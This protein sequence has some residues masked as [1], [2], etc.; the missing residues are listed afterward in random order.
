M[1][2]STARRIAALAFPFA[3]AACASTPPPLAPTAPAAPAPIVQTP[4]EPEP[5]WATALEAGLR[6]VPAVTPT[7]EEARRALDAFITS[8]PK[9]L[10]RTDQSLLTVAADWAPLCAE[11]RTISPAQA[12]TFFASRFAWV[13]IGRGD[14]FATGYFEPEIAGSRVPTASLNAPVYG[15]P[16]DLTRGTFADGSGEGRG[17]LDAD[18][19]FVRYYDRAAIEAGALRGRGL[20]IAYADPVDLFFLQIQGSGRLLMPDGEVVRIGYANQNGREYVAIG[21]LLRERGIMESGSITLDAL[22]NYL[23]ADPVRGAALMNENPSYVFFREL[24]G[25]GPLGALEVPVVPVGSVAADPKFVPLGAPVWLDMENDAADGLWVAQDT[26]GAIKGANRFDTFWGA[27][28][29]A[30]RVAGIMSSN[31]KALL[32][33]PRSAVSR[34]RATR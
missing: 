29:A 28:P 21:R 6:E 30:K 11:A 8:C 1:R 5:T 17:R 13:E 33:L 24:T 10:A 27:G 12:A 31:G 25:E 22:Q 23:R 3:L 2:R 15:V 4:S 16:Q 19:D 26:G 9:L 18:G 14:A 7:S 20:E 32:L 34:A